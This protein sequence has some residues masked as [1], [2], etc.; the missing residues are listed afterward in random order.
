[1]NSNAVEQAGIQLTYTVFT[2]TEIY[3]NTTSVIHSQRH[4][5]FTLFFNT[6]YN[7]YQV[8]ITVTTVG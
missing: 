8:T 2:T 1:M 3:C 4:S 6:T 5:N 7:L